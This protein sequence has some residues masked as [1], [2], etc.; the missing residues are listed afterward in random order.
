MDKDILIQSRR[1]D[2]LFYVFDP[3]SYKYKNKSR[4]SLKKV[5]W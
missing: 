2:S 5:V 4:K 1:M 3:L